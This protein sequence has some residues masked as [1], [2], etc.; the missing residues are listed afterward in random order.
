MRGTTSGIL[1]TTEAMRKATK[2]MEGRTKG[3]N[4]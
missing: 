2:K 4:I 1:E 3:R